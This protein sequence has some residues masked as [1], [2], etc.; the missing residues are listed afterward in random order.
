MVLVFINLLKSLNK[1]YKKSY[2]FSCTSIIK[3]SNNLAEVIVDG[4]V[5]MNLTQ[6]KEYHYFLINR[7]HSYT[8]IFE[9]QKSIVSFNKIKN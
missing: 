6:D 7:I 3:L 5:E 4:G 9:A 1:I 2:K 8:Y